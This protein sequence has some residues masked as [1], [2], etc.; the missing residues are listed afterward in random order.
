MLNLDV[1]ISMH[2]YL[3][4]HPHPVL[5]RKG[6][7]VLRISQWQFGIHVEL[8]VEATMAYGSAPVCIHLRILF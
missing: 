5:E 8:Q 3:A 7:L 6:Q 4:L 1:H 2:I